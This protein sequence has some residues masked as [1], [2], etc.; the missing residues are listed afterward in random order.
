MDEQLNST[1]QYIHGIITDSNL[2]SV[3][4]L[5]NLSSVENV[6]GVCIDRSLSRRP[7]QNGMS[8]VTGIAV[9]KIL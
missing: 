9:I 6:L 5:P 8:H 2:R 3:E 1:I 7:N 4:R